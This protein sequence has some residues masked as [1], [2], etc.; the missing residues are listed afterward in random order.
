MRFVNSRS[1]FSQAAGCEK[2]TVLNTLAGMMQ[3]SDFVRAVTLAERSA[4]SIAAI[5]PKIWPGWRSQRMT[6]LP[7]GVRMSTRRSPETMK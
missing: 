7:A 6:S 5:S 4:P 3:S 1:T 2:S